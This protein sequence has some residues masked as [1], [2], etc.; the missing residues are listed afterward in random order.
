MFAALIIGLAAPSLFGLIAGEIG[1]RKPAFRGRGWAIFALVLIVSMWGLREFEHN[2]ALQLATGGD[3]GP[4]PTAEDPNPV[5]PQIVRMTVSP[6]PVNPFRWHAVIETPDYYQLATV[7]TLANTVATSPSRDIVPKPPTTLFTL[8]AKRS[9]LGEVYLDWS[10]F[11]IVEDIGPV[12]A[13]GQP[14]T[15]EAN[16]GL[17]AVTFRDLRFMYTTFLLDGR[18]HT[19]LTGTVL[20]NDDRR[21]VQMEMDN[22]LQR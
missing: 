19:P 11:P 21:V 13:D 18:L 6:Y 9:W 7:D 16:T 2:A 8:V 12:T 14:T 17:R 5:V 4:A 15:L 3:Y 10:S 20:L 22:R 1:A